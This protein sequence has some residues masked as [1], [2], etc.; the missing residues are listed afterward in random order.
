ML[1]VRKM[2]RYG[3]STVHAIA[4]VCFLSLIKKLIAV[5]HGGRPHATAVTR[6]GCWAA[7]Y[8]RQGHC[9]RRLPPP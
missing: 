8:R 1:S 7:S 2:L 5:A 9:N 6:G 3:I 4:N